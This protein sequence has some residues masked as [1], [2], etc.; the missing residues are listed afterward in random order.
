[1]VHNLDPLEELSRRMR[2]Q[3]MQPG[4]ME[5]LMEIAR[6]QGRSVKMMWIDDPNSLQGRVA[7]EYIELHNGLPPNFQVLPRKQ[8]VA[9]GRKLDAADTPIDEQKRILLLLAHHPSQEALD[10]IRRYSRLKLSPEMRAWTGLAQSE[11]E[12]F[13][14]EKRTDR[15]VD[16]ITFGISKISRNDPCPCGSGKK[17]KNCCGR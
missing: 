17:F 7:K 11:C 8:I 5:R 4:N 1:M 14:E 16:S 10:A 9:E 3:G 15:P 2:A 12:Q 13:I 6:K